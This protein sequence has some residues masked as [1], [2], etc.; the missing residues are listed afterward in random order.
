MQYK[1][2]P[3]PTGNDLE[4][5]KNWLQGELS[6]I[7]SELNQVKQLAMNVQNPIPQRYAR[8]DIYY[9]DAGV[10]GLVEGPYFYDGN[11]WHFMG[12]Y[13]PALGSLYFSAPFV[14]SL[15]VANTFV[16]V[17]PFTQQAASP[18]DVVQNMAAGTLT[19]Q[20]AGVY[21]AQGFVDFINPAPNQSYSIAF[22]K[23]GVIA[24]LTESRITVKD[25]NDGVNLQTIITASL[26]PG[27]VIDIRMKCGAIQNISLLSG[28]LSLIQQQ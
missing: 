25:N 8:G 24:P 13:P 1:N 17:A 5:L 28:L 10:V 4:V 23:N 14:L 16:K 3:P 26:V 27:D 11:R 19:V 2:N 9:F 20:R 22:F 21:T 18:V 15:P 6:R 7:S 12:D